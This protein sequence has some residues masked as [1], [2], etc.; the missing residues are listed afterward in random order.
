V[1]PCLVPTD[2][3]MFRTRKSTLI[4]RLLA[5]Q[6]I[7]SKNSFDP[8]SQALAKVFLKELGDIET[9]S[10][11]LKVLKSK[12][13]TC[14]VL[15][16]LPGASQTVCRLWRWSQ[17]KVSPVIKKLPTCSHPREQCI[18]PFHFCVVMT[19]LPCIVNTVCRDEFERF[20]SEEFSDSGICEDM[21]S[22]TYNSETRHGSVGWCSIAYWEHNQ[23]IG[24]LRA[25][26][27]PLVRIAS[28][29]DTAEGISLSE[30]S[31]NCRDDDT[32]RV[33][34]HVGPGVMFSLE[35]DGIWLYNRS[36]I[37]IFIQSPTLSK[38]LET[39]PTV[40]KVLPGHSLNS[41]HYNVGSIPKAA[42]TIR[43]SF[44]KGWG[45]GYKRQFVTNSP[46]W[47]ELLLCFR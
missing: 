23:R 32:S 29:C 24:S 34:K 35:D 8:Q 7:S 10:L 12:N 36:E 19:P 2:V 42:R 39:Q 41:Y 4:K 6:E 31:N 47:L 14:C 5:L 45:P 26:S 46:C 30:V 28:V 43:L 15:V 33:R 38:S 9:L 11:L 20:Q 37:S 40:H 25:V 44:E 27:Q 22:D 16:D 21:C 1:L 18:N 17:C 3:F 13:S